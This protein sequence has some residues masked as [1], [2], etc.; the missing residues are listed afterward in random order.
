MSFLKDFFKNYLSKVN[1]YMLIIII[2]VIMMFTSG[3]SNLIKRYQ[4]DKQ[5]Q[6]LEREIKRYQ[7]DIDVNKKK[8]DDLHTDKEGL[9]RFAREEYYMKKP[10]EDVFIIREK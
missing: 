1:A 5:I 7:K 9:E 4:Y 10:N 8:L 3:D 6:S 2:F